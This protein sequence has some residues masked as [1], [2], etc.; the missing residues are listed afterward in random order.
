MLFRDARGEKIS[1]VSQ[2]ALVDYATRLAPLYAGVLA[3][4]KPRATPGPGEDAEGVAILALRAMRQLMELKKFARVG[5]QA[6]PQSLWGEIHRIHGLASR[7]GVGPAFEAAE[8]ERR[9]VLLRQPGDLLVQ[10]RPQVL[11]GER[12]RRARVAVRGRPDYERFRGVVPTSDGGVSAGASPTL[13][14]RNPR[15]RSSR[16]SKSFSR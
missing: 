13:T 2:R 16:L 8:H 15:S 14:H 1:E 11:R 12:L 10:H 4:S 3:S 6:P 5:Y 9:P 7:L